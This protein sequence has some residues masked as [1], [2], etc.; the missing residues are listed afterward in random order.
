MMIAVAS[1]RFPPDESRYQSKNAKSI[2]AK[3]IKIVTH[4]LRQR[5]RHY[6]AR[7][8]IY[9]GIAFVF[10]FLTHWILIFDNGGE[11][12]RSKIDTTLYA[13]HQMSWSAAT[14]SGR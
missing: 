10:H 6:C 3:K 14:D 7:H 12:R 1:S 9:I 8:V 2:P 5:L 11:G 13:H 4:F